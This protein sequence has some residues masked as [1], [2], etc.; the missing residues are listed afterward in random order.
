MERT[1]NIIRTSLLGIA[2][3]LV[4]VLFKTGVGLFTHSIAVLLDAVNNLSDAL[5]SVITIVGARLAGKRPDKKHPFG[6]GRIEYISAVLIAV[7]VFAAGIL[8][9]KESI[10]K[11][12]NPSTAEYTVL[13]LVIIAVAVVV[14]LL[15]GSH[16]RKVGKKL[17]SEALTASGSDAFFDAVLSFA[18]LIAGVICLIWGLS[19]EG[20]LGVLISLAILKA[21]LEILQ[22]SLSSIIGKRADP[23]LSRQ[24]KARI[25]TF[26]NV[27]G[28]Y[29]LTLHNYGPTQIVGSVHIEVPDDMTAKDLHRLTRRIAATVYLDF[30]IVLTVGVYAS[31]NDSPELSALRQRVEA[32]VAGEPDILQMHGFYVDEAQNTVLF[33]LIVTFDADGSAIRKRLLKTLQN[34]YPKMKFDIVLD[35]DLSD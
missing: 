14:K 18:T 24:L 2:A 27:R 13:S 7:L 8:S 33:D 15:I 25:C 26:P 29:D 30:G 3:N 4:L 19:L 12:L 34:E 32:L 16:F 20:Y 31:N 23:E 10:E 22:D 17:N 6:H 5:S 11:I 35:A 9:M 28:V 1:R 21:G